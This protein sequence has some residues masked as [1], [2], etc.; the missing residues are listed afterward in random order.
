MACTL[1][2]NESTN[3]AASK[4]VHSEIEALRACSLRCASRLDNASGN[5]EH[6]PAAPVTGASLVRRRFRSSTPRLNPVLTDDLVQRH[7]E[8]TGDL[9]QGLAGHLLLAPA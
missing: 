7:I 8:L 9:C 2:H 6:A 5:V 4:F 3:S 1:S